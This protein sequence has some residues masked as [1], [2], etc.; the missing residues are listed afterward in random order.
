M[1]SHKL[2]WWEDYGKAENHKL[3]LWEGNEKGENKNRLVEGFVGNGKPQTNLMGGLWEGENHKLGWQG[4]MGRRNHLL[5][6]WRVVERG[7]PQTSWL[8]VMG[9]VKG[10]QSVLDGGAL[11]PNLQI[12][13]LGHKTLGLRGVMQ[14]VLITWC[15]SWRSFFWLIRGRWMAHIY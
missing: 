12:Q 7:K 11:D 4:V 15:R 6:W 3:G 8:M 10:E 1:G 13:S 9:K 5:G 2:S 14:N